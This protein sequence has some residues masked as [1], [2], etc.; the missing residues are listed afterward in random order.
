MA[1]TKNQILQLE[2]ESLSSDGNGVA[3]SD[4]QA[5]FVPGTAPG[6][7]ARQKEFLLLRLDKYQAVNIY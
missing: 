5:I 2:I 4:G 3:H 1:F 7:F 6:D